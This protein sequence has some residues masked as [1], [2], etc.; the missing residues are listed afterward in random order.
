MQYKQTILIRPIHKDLKITFSKFTKIQH[1]LN[2]KYFTRENC[3]NK[4]A[5]SLKKKNILKVQ[6]ILI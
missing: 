1:F 5:I 2:K 4:I 3:Y 6:D